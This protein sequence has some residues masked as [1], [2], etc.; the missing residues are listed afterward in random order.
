[1]KFTFFDLKAILNSDL[2]NK[3]FLFYKI[4]KLYYDILRNCDEG[5]DYHHRVRGGFN[6]N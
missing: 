2:K 1:M 6:N 5:Y 4:N 3:S